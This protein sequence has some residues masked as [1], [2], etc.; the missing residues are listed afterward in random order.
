MI[1]GLLILGIVFATAMWGYKHFTT[2][3]VTIMLMLLVHTLGFGLTTV[4]G[5][6]TNVGTIMYSG[7]MFGLF[8]V[9]VLHGQKWAQE[10]KH[11]T[12]LILIAY[13]AIASSISTLVLHNNAGD[14]Y[15]HLYSYDLQVTVGSFLAFY[16]SWS[17]L[18]KMV[19]W[20]RANTSSMVLIA[21]M[22]MGVA[23]IID[24]VIFF[25]IAFTGLYSVQEMLMIG[26]G[27]LV[28]KMIFVVCSLPLIWVLDQYGVASM[29]HDI[30]P[31]QSM[32]DLA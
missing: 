24:S 31:A 14:I 15:H 29:Y 6:T 7:V 8:L 19:D 4:W 3:T 23:Q 12:A 28:L 25:P 5:F 1:T 11:K 21:F 27:G 2:V 30:D 13:A 9:Y 20:L 16:I 18:I 32:D 22:A 26:Y 17:V 10:V